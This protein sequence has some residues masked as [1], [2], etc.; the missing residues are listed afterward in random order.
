METI[1]KNGRPHGLSRWLNITLSWGAT[2]NSVRSILIGHAGK[3]MLCDIWH[4]HMRIWKIKTYIHVTKSHRHPPTHTHTLPPTHT[5]TR[6]PAPARAQAHTH[7]RESEKI[8]ETVPISFQLL[9]IVVEQLMRYKGVKTSGVPF[10][11]W[12]LLGLSS[13]ITL[14]EA[15]SR[16]V[17]TF[18]N[19]TRKSV[20]KFR[21]KR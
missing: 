16:K 20:Y 21:H 5:H 4:L 9:I 12:G 13:I 18:C 6:A 15:A 10:I 1:N 19:V 7:N 3:V 17:G 8:E 11:F 2:Y 14:Y